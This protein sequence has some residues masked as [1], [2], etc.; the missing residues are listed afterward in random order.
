MS[1]K[2]LKASK[3]S[4]DKSAGT[5]RRNFLK[6]AALAAAA[7]G[8]G[9]LT[10]APKADPDEAA[11][12]GQ[13]N[14]LPGHIVLYR[15][16]NINGQTGTIDASV[17]ES[18]VASGVRLLTGISDTG[19]AFK[20]LFPGI[21]STSTMAIKVNCIGSTDTRWETVAGILSGL[22]QIPVGADEYYD[23]SQVVVYDRHNLSN[24]G[25][26]TA[27]F[28]FNG[29]APA[30]SSS[31]NY[32]SSYYVYGSYRLSDYL[33]QCDYVINMPAL[34]S[35]S[36]GN[37]MIT[38]A[39][40]NHYG[41][42]Y[43]SSLCGNITGMLSVNA[44]ANLKEKTSL[45]LMDGIRGTFNGGPSTAPM[46]WNIFEESTPNTLF[47][48]TDPVTNEYWA[49]DMINTERLS[50]GPHH[51][52]YSSTKDCP[53]IETAAAAPYELGVCDP[54][55]MTVT[56]YTA[57]GVDTEEVRSQR[58]LQFTETFPNPFTTSTRLRF[59]LAAPAS[60]AMVITDI[61]GRTVRNLG[62]A[63]CP[64]GISEF[65]WDG[66]N[67]S[68]QRISSGVYFARIQAMGEIRIKRVI[69]TQ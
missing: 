36:N 9:P 11:A 6:I 33:L 8:A 61:T 56:H 57:S 18:S 50:D 64:A 29:N 46:Y 4:D 68:G 65:N 45:V 40:K 37:N 38:T 53:W 24:H 35:H 22:A 12:V 7:A 55:Q 62:E 23:I 44:D 49:R 42:C 15:N 47:L 66:R 30:I 48:S 52:P 17:V 3:S 13:Y 27:R 63:S 20:S 19:L 34:K 25:Y 32:N 41:S 31:N 16:S 58:N 54:E 10:G 59:Q 51:D 5:S 60:A 26:T 21:T 2:D 14:T 28:T 67:D 1:G 39:L 69:L 43:P